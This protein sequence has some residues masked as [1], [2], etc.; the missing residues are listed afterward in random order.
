[1]IKV[2]SEWFLPSIGLFLPLTA[3]TKLAIHSAEWA[4]SFLDAT[5]LALPSSECL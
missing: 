3:A 5:I 2:S 1:L 4:L